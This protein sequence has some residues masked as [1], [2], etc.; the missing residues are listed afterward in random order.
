MAVEKIFRF[1]KLCIRK[2]DRK[3]FFHQR[4]FQHLVIEMVRFKIVSLLS[5]PFPLLEIRSLFQKETVITSR[6]RERESNAFFSRHLKIKQKLSGYEKRKKRRN[7]S[8]YSIATFPIA[9]KCSGIY[10]IFTIRQSNLSIFKRFLRI[11]FIKFDKKKKKKETTL[12]I[13]SWM[14]S[15]FFHIIFL[16]LSLL[17]FFFLILLVG[18][19]VES[20]SN[21]R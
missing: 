2:L 20:P 17:S 11:R 9:R 8:E 21:F 10:W 14:V 19:R 15:S 18:K 5:T 4:C 3:P 6:E 12:D 1:A 13:F 7:L 16:L